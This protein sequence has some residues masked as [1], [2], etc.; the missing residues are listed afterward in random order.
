R[1]PGGSVLLR[2]FAG[3]WVRFKSALTRMQTLVAH[4]TV[5]TKD[6]RMYFVEREGTTAK[7]QQLEVDQF[8]TIRPW[9][10]HFFGDSAGEAREQAKARARR[11]REA[12]NNA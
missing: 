3:K 8:G 2:R 7:L 9:P 1:S 12:E 10:E 5:K 11:M 6:L 4:D